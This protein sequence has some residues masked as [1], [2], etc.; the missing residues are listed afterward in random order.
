MTATAVSTRPAMDRQKI[1]VYVLIAVVALAGVKVMLPKFTGSSNDVSTASKAAAGKTFTLPKVLTE[2]AT[3]PADWVPAARNPFAPQPAKTG[4]EIPLVPGDTAAAQA[5]VALA[6]KAIEATHVKGKGFSLT[7]DGLKAQEPT[8][9]WVNQPLDTL[10][11][12]GLSASATQV[13]WLTGPSFA[14]LAVK[15]DNGR[16]LLLHASEAADVVRLQYA[17]LPPSGVCAA[18]DSLSL[19]LVWADDPTGAGW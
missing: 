14:N 3:K 12:G 8:L 11:S 18:T 6:W 1:G 15:A 9:R 17:S 16:C 7:L 13:S 10:H 2:A 4:V 5:T 19:G